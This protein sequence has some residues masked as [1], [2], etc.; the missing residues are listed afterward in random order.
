LA[1]ALLASW[2]TGGEDFS[3]FAQKVPGLYVVIG[4][5]P[6]GQDASKAEANHSPR[7][8]VD[9]PSLAVGTRTLAQLTVDYL[10]MG[11]KP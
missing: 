2:P 6:V 4:S 3:F 1:S 11:G 5:T 8:Y 10:A 9:E 7:F